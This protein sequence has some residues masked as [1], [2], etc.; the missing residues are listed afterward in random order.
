MDLT[1]YLL[2]LAFAIIIGGL[3]GWRLLS[4]TSVTKK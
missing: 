2:L 3:A 1:L 4:K